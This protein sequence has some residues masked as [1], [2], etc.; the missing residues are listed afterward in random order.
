MKSRHT[1][2]PWTW[3]KVVGDG[4]VT[5][6]TLNGPDVLC[7]FWWDK[8]PSAD[9]RLIANAPTLLDICKEFYDIHTA[10]CATT[11]EFQT[12]LEAARREA[13]KVIAEVDGQ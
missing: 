8:P 13:A 1:P 6:F 5:E 3:E 10:G 12:R 9:A 2:A 7:R 4:K 11:A